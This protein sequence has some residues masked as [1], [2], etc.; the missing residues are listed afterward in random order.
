MTSAYVFLPIRPGQIHTAKRQQ[1][2][3]RFCSTFLGQPC[4][5]SAHVF[6]KQC[7]KAAGPSL[8]DSVSSELGH[9]GRGVTVLKR[10]ERPSP[11]LRIRPRL[12]GNPTNVAYPR[13]SDVSPN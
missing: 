3:W 5:D 7:L 10:P 4:V 13:Q 11:A 12:H 1:E 9:Q 8:H 6:G 2:S